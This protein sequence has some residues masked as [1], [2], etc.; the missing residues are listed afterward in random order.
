MTNQ[1]ERDV[2]VTHEPLKNPISYVRGTDAIPI[3]F[4]FRDYDIPSGASVSVFVA[5]PSGK[6]VYNSA[7]ISGND[8]TVT[9]DSQMFM[10]LGTSEMQVSISQGGKELVQFAQPVNVKANL[11]AGDLPDSSTSSSFLDD[12]I[13][14]AQEAVNNANIAAKQAQTAVQNANLAVSNANDAVD[15]VNAMI[16]SM[17]ANFSSLAQSANITQLQ[18]TSK[19]LVGAIN[20]LNSN[21][22]KIT[23]G[24]GQNA[25]KITLSQTNYSGGCLLFALRSNVCKTGVFAIS[26]YRTTPDGVLYDLISLDNTSYST[27]KDGDSVIISG[28][29]LTQY[30]EGICMIA[31]NPASFTIT[32]FKLN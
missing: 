31:G 4:H 28:Q 17:G 21:I 30:S 25:L 12:M 6:A 1:I 26:V 29:L 15:S 11:K 5:K 19:N 8:V 3:V 24:N 23:F 22:S 18:T 2:Y 10:E 9:V 20:E 14:Q 16:S 7:T 32:P 27:T 13:A